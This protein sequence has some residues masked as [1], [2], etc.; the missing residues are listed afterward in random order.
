MKVQSPQ[1]YVLWGLG[2][3]G[4]SARFLQL[5]ASGGGPIDPGGSAAVVR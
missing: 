4:W 5:I 1:R 2:A 3:R